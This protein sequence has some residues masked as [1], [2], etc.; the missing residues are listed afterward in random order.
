MRKEEDKKDK[1][2]LSSTIHRTA[3]AA[4]LFLTPC[5]CATA[6][7]QKKPGAARTQSA[8]ATLSGPDAVEAILQDIQDNMTVLTDMHW[9]KGEYNHIIHVDKMI[10]AADPGNVDAYSNAA[11][12][13]WSMDRD[14]EAV[15]MYEMGIKNNVASAYMYDE[16]GFYYVLRKR[17]H[18]RALPYYEKAAAMKDCKP[19]T[20]HMLANCY[21]KVG[22]LE[23]ALA[24]WKRAASIAD[25]PALPKAKDELERLKRLVEQSKQK[26]NR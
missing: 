21:E 11:W 23:K 19:F 2:M 6:E 7:A 24:T 22:Q 15:A 8:K 17:D 13:L 18:R 26:R 16:L 12:L 1:T 14:D 5:L 25:N 4:F 9:H 10:I 20:L 3:V